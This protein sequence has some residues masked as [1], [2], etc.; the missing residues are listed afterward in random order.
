MTGRELLNE[1]LKQSDKTLDKYDISVVVGESAYEDCEFYTLRKLCF[2]DDDGYRDIDD[3][4][5][6]VLD[7]GSPVLV[8]AQ[9]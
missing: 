4:A 6:G 3:L 8:S 5:N 2:T 9:F 1:L 7:S